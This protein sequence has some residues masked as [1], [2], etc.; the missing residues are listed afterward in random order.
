MRKRAHK[1]A[2]ELSLSK[3]STF[4]L[5]KFNFW[6]ATFNV[7][8]TNSLQIALQPLHPCINI[9]K[10]ERGSTGGMRER[11][12]KRHKI[13]VILMSGSRHLII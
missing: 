11:H 2:V 3:S 10:W 9:Q 12:E 7:L 5:Q 1:Y 8:K 4:S 6:K 13:F